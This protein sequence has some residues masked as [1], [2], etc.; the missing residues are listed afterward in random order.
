MQSSYIIC[1]EGVRE[2][3][4]EHNQLAYYEECERGLDHIGKS[5]ACGLGR[6]CCNGTD[7]PRAI[8]FNVPMEAAFVT[9]ISHKFKARLVARV[10]DVAEG[11]TFRLL[12]ILIPVFDSIELTRLF[13]KTGES[14]R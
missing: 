14:G 12:E 13:F 1:L 9:L 3:E 8:P 4:L 7:V 10:P 2:E 5:Q 11:V 6:E